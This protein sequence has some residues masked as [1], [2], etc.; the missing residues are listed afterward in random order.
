MIITFMDLQKPTTPQAYNWHIILGIQIIL[1]FPIPEVV[2]T[3]M[4]Q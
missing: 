4:D 1:L 2:T 3:L